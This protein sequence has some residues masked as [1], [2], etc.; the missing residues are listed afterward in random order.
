M[1]YEKPQIARL[2]KAVVAIQG[3]P[4]Q[5]SPNPDSQ[6]QANL[7]TVAAYEADE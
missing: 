4:K 3:M 7:V 6:R 5:W 2:D 1:K